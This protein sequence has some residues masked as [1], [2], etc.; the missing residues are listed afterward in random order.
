MS[1]SLDVRSLSSVTS[2]SAEQ[3]MASVLGWLRA[4]PRR[5]ELTIFVQSGMTDRRNRSLQ[6]AL[7]ALGCRVTLTSAQRERLGVPA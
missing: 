2:A 3:Q 6:S 4:Y 1:F 5:G 7:L